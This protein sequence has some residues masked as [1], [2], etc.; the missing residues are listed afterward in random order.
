MKVLGIEST[1]DETG[2]AVVVDG[3]TILSNVVA[4]SADI[5]ER[6][7]G[8]FPELAARRHAEVIR[9]VVE[10]AL[11]GVG[12]VDL[13]AVARGPGLIG[14][15]LVGLQ[16]AKGLSIAWDKPLIGVNHVE[17]HLYA[18]MM[19]REAR[20]PALGLVLSGGHT[21]MLRIDGPGQYTKLGTTVDDA[22]GEAYDKVASML[23]LPYPGGPHVEKLALEGNPQNF[24]LKAGFVKRSPLD[25]SFSGLKTAVLYALRDNP[26]QKAD[27]AAA[28]QETALLDLVKKAKTAAATFDCQAIYLGGGVSCNRR[29]KT[30]FTENFE[31]VFFPPPALT[32]D[33][34]A[35]IAGLGYQKFSQTKV[36]DPLDLEALTRIPI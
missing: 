16:F 3:K 35:M 10:E 24:S 19:E 29:L 9:P 34:A 23:G 31:R 18:A 22:I 25:F 15:L 4:S 7:G 5:H 32:L 30:L 14:S 13:I 1:C 36:S 21:L 17:A 8:V 26:T 6:Y 28:F 27:L 11:N 20:F 2:A 33:N 12:E